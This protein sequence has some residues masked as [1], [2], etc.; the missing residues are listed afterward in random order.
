MNY[1][2]ELGWDIKVYFPLIHIFKMSCHEMSLSGKEFV[3]A[4]QIWITLEMEMGKVVLAREKCIVIF[5][6]W[7][8][9]S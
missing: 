3:S 4:P 2:Y 6:K 1:N 8:V 7:G 9:L 5:W